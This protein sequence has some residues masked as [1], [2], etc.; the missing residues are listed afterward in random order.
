VNGLELRPPGLGEFHGPILCPI[1]AGAEVGGQKKTAG[2]YPSA[3]GMGDLQ[4]RMAPALPTRRWIAAPGMGTHRRQHATK[5][6][7]APAFGPPP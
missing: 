3:A 1:A 7:H 5:Y 4:R 6:Y 2:L